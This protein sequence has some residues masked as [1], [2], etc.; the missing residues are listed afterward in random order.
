MH[1]VFEMPVLNFLKIIMIPCK[2]QKDIHQV[3]Q[4]KLFKNC[5][6][7]RVPTGYHNKTSVQKLPKYM[8]ENFI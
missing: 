3:Q 1:F 8:T 7:Q 2:Y 4:L 5:D 6:T